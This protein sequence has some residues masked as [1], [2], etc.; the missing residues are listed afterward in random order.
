MA[1]MMRDDAQQPAQQRL[2]AWIVVFEP[3]K[4]GPVPDA[5]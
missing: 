2:M 4:Q 1:I 3:P 5:G